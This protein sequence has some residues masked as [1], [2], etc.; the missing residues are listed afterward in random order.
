MYK[1]TSF[2]FLLTSGLNVFLYVYRLLLLAD[3]WQM[4]CSR[5]RISHRWFSGAAA[6]VSGRNECERKKEINELYI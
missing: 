4:C 1:Q 6:L 3:V 5:F 2:G